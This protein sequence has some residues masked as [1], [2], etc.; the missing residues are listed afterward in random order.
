MH[1]Y[2][3]YVYTVKTPINSTLEMLDSVQFHVSLNKQ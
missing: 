2:K 3:N 1:I